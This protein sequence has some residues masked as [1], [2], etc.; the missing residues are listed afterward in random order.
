MFLNDN[1]QTAFFEKKYW[2]DKIF[3][4]QI[5]FGFLFKN[6][7]QQKTS[8]KYYKTRIFNKTLSD[9]TFKKIVSSDYM[10]N[11]CLVNIRLY[12]ALL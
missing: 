4:K 12:Q 8:L 1:D 3:R 5:L 10:D 7:C 11:H 6:S 2:K 9:K